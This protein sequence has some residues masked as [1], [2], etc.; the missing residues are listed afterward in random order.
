[1]TTKYRLPDWL[2]GHEARVQTRFN[3]GTV[4]VWVEDHASTLLTLPLRELVEVKPP[5]IDD[6]VE[7][8]LRVV[9][10]FEDGLE[11]FGY[12]EN[13]DAAAYVQRFGRNGL[14][15][16]PVDLTAEQCRDAARALWKLGTG[17]AS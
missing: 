10:P 9:D 16:S 12:E 1:M 13:A 7:L 5:S 8:P 2:G 6:P 15:G 14:V 4:Q 17:G 11:I 3:D